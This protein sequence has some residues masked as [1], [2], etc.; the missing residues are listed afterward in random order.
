MADANPSQHP[1][2]ASQRDNKLKP[3]QV[4]RRAL[5][6]E[7]LSGITGVVLVL[8]MWGHMFFVSSILTGEKNFNLIADIF[9]YTWLAQI[10]I[11]VIVIVFFVHFVTAS[12][13]IPRGLRDRKKMLELGK[14]IKNSQSN[15]HQDKTSDIRL[16]SHSET[17]LWIWQ[18]RS[19]MIILVLGSIHLFVV[20]A[21]IVQRSLGGVGIT[22]LESTTRVG[23]GLWILYV[24]LLICVEFHAGIGLYRF[25]VKWGTG[26]QIP[27]IGEITRRRS[28][29]LE[30]F[31]FVFFIIVGLITLA[32]L[33]GIMDP[34][35]E[36]L[37]AAD[38]GNPA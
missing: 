8:F 31:V 22:A 7:W 23:S 2:I 4:A 19:G 13:K 20:G 21:D 17:T 18:V 10:T 9:E 25:V 5:I 12:R 14:S 37:L 35:L 34:P 26:K 27:L 36:S 29:I 24:V 6:K 16:R 28:H 32:V 15:W 1:D 38:L 33:S 3:F 30:R 11:L